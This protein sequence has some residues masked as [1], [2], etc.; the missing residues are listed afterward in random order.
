MPC[1]Q[2]G[3]TLP[4]L[5][6]VLLVVI[7]EVDVQGFLFPFKTGEVNPRANSLFGYP[8]NESDLSLNGYTSLREGFA[9]DS[10]IESYYLGTI[11]RGLLNAQNSLNLVISP[12][13]TLGSMIRERIRENP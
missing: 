6:I 1:A 5:R 13:K 2:D 7:K 10:R 9:Q 8:R 11:N 12:C 3:S 4:D